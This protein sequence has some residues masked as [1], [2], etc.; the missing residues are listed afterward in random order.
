MPE[1]CMLRD[2]HA[3]GLLYYTRKIH[4][5]LSRGGWQNQPP[6]FTTLSSSHPHTV[7]MFPQSQS[8]PRWSGWES[9]SATE[10]KYASQQFRSRE[11]RLLLAA[12]RSVGMSQWL[13][14]KHSTVLPLNLTGQLVSVSLS[15]GIT[16]PASS[17]SGCRNL[18]R[19][20]P[21]TCSKIQSPVY[22]WNCLKLHH[23][24]RACLPLAPGSNLW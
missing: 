23:C 1:T 11:T 13:C 6:P 19:L 7:S 14:P 8:L 24:E 12:S 16:F 18:S 10:C 21:N 22:S 3:E 20:F 9:A 2:L 17:T 15:I 5:M 4:L